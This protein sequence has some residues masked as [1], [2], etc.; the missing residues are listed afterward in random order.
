MFIEVVLILDLLAL[1]IVSLYSFGRGAIEDWYF[2]DVV[3]CVMNVLV[4]VMIESMCFWFI[5]CFA[6]ML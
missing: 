6:S 4:T 5:Y 3:S 1:A 2:G